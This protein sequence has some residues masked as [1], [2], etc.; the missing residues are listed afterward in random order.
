M[1][2]CLTC[3]FITVNTPDGQMTAHAVLL[4]CCVDLAAQAL[5]INMKQFNGAYACNYCEHKGVPRTNHLHRNWPYERSMIRTH[6][7]MLQNARDALSTGEYVS[8]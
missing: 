7:S 2:F 8:V 1:L 3:I 6:H 4:L 5:L